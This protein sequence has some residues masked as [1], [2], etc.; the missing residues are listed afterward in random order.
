MLLRKLYRAGWTIIIATVRGDSARGIS[1]RW[2]RKWAVPHHALLMRN[3]N[4]LRP[5]HEVKASMFKMIS[6]D[7]IALVVDDEQPVID[8]AM[9]L[10]LC[11]LKMGLQRPEY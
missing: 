5:S 10:G 2:L 9:E 4:D 1:Y 11:A 8:A 7:N 3:M 6:V